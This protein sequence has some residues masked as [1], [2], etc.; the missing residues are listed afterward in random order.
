MKKILTLLFICTM[1]IAWAQPSHAP[2]T[3]LLSK[4]VSSSGKVDYVALKKDIS[5]LDSYLKT[6]EAS[7]PTEKWSSNTT[8][9]YWINAYNAYTLKM[10]LQHYPLK[11][12]TDIKYGEQN[13]WDYKW[14]K[15]AGATLSLNDIEHKKLRAKYKD[16][17]IHFAVNCASFSCPILL[18]KAY[19]ASTLE[20]Q[21]DTQAS[22]FINDSQRN[23]ITADKVQISEIFKWYKDDFASAGSI[24]NYLNKYSKIKIKSTAKVEYLSYNWNINA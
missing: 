19:E 10:M 12:I 1:T 5:K 4:H 6:L 15:I 2:F 11:S 14:I 17:R 13:A 21:L 8:K 16:P 22:L 20:T 3:Q 9:A 24:I 18:N 23:K 7:T